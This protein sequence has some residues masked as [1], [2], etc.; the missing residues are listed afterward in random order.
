[1]LFLLFTN[2]LHTSSDVQSFSDDSTLHK[3]SFFLSQPSFSARS[4]SRLAT[5]LTINLDL[6]SIFDWGV[7]N[8]V[9]FNISKT[10][11]LTVFS[12]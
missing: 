1:M 10:Q 4:Q 2:D 9:K 5:S 8:L 3:S 6:Q 7:H 11:F 12:I